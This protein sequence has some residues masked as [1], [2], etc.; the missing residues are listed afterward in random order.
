[1]NKI[2]I[3][4]DVVSDVVCPWCYIGKRRL[5]DALRRLPEN[6]EAEVRH[7]PFELN[8]NLPADGTPQK[9]HLR[10]KFGGE[11][12]YHELTQR[13]SSIA[14]TEGLNFDF[15][16]QAVLP[17]T[18][19][20]HRLIQFAPNAEIQG[21]VV[22][23]LMK[24]YFEEGV[25][26]SNR[27]NLLD[28]VA[29]AGLDKQAAASLLDSQTDVPEIRKMEQLNH[30]RGITGVP[31]FIINDKYGVSGAQTSDTLLQVFS[32]AGEEAAAKG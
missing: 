11:E 10:N 16:M 9:E 29:K 17:N 32:E 24:A 20:A 2:K 25:D 30:Q 15:A 31:F 27:E 13:V 19:D 4:I 6:M 18:L 5:E 8:P 22:E 23:S 7:L 3:K 26:L 14:K 28:V 12:R 21:S 1:M